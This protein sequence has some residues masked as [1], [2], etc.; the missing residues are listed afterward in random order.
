MAGRLFCKAAFAAFLGLGIGGLAQAQWCPPAIPSGYGP[1]PPAAHPP[2]PPPG[3]VPPGGSEACANGNGAGG[4]SKYSWLQGDHP[5][6]GCWTHHNLFGCGSF[7]SE[8]NFIFG[9]CR[10][11]FGQA[12]LKEP[13]PG[14]FA[15][16]LDG[17]PYA[18][19]PPR[20]KLPFG[21]CPSCR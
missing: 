19:P 1:L 4:G 7:R 15:P 14:E 5:I 12:C 18:V 20:A 6:V 8:T 17:T 2:I 3:Q 13:P 11:F 21:F 9:S 10:S 16:M